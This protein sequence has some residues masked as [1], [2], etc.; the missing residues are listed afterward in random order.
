MCCCHCKVYHYVI[1]SCVPAFMSKSFRQSASLS[2]CISF[3]QRRYQNRAPSSSS[4]AMPSLAHIP[5]NCWY[6]YLIDALRGLSIPSWLFFCLYFVI[7][8]SFACSFEGRSG[9]PGNRGTCLMYLGSKVAKTIKEQG[10]FASYRGITDNVAMESYS[11]FLL[12]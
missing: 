7:F 5:I 11:S 10:N 12:V 1:L 2:C 6:I 9:V 4:G 8:A 3:P